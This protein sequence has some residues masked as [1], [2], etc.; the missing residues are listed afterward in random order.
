MRGS[1]SEQSAWARVLLVATYLV[2]TGV[3]LLAGVVGAFLVPEQVGSF[4]YLSTV[5][6]VVGNLAV[7]V[8]G[9]IGAASR[10][11][12][13]APFFGWFVAVG[14]LSSEPVVSKGGDVVIPGTLGNAPGVVHAGLAFMAAGVV[15]ALVPIVIASRFTKPP[16]AP[17]SHS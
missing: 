1:W 6:A 4:G 10:A 14:A 13:V 17:K 5:V 9:G 11:G 8:I 12:A 15:A 3:G 16:Y 2:L 7:G